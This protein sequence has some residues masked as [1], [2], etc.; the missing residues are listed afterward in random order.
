MDVELQED[1]RLDPLA[2]GPR[3][4]RMSDETFMRIYR[5][6]LSPKLAMIVGRLKLEP[7]DFG[8]ANKL[9]LFVGVIT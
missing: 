2:I 7:M 6:Q 9:H 3:V 1:K 8:I 5:K 4:L